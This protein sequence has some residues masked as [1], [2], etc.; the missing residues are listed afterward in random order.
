MN[1]NNLMP[2]MGYNEVNEPTAKKS[3][4]SLFGKLFE[5]RDFAH[6][7]HLQTKSYSQHKALG[8]FYES[9]VDLADTFFETHAG[10]YG[11]SKFSMSAAPTNADV[12]NY[13]ESLA[14]ITTD[15]HS[16]I[17]KKDTHLHNI[18]DEITGEVYHLLYKLKNLK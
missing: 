9:I 14:K 17:D 1:D 13:F 12:I 7:A 3:I 2:P 5:A 6:Y 11:I 4:S 10:Q 8:S 16:A 15:Y 18:L